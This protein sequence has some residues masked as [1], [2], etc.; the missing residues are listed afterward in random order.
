MNMY[1]FVMRVVLHLDHVVLHLDVV[2]YDLET[3]L[4]FI[5]DVSDFEN[6]IHAYSGL[7]PRG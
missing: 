7:P 3:W 6:S 2:L 5:M 4:R 1:D